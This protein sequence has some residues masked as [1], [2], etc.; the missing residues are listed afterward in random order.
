MKTLAKSLLLL[1][2][3]VFS[4]C[5]NEPIGQA[6]YPTNV[7]YTN[8]ELYNLIGRV[9]ND[10]SETQI[11]CIQFIYS[12]RL[13]VFDQDQELLYVELIND[14]AAFSTLLDNLQDGESI[15]LN[16]PIT[17]VNGNGE[18]IEINNNEELKTAIDACVDKEVI[19]NCNG[20][21]CTEACAWAVSNYIGNDTNF[22][23]LVLEI[24]SDNLLAIYYNSTIY[25]GTWIT[26]LTDDQLYVNIDLNADGELAEAF[27]SEWK[28]DYYTDEIMALSNSDK[29]FEL[30]INCELPCDEEV[31]TICEFEPGIAVFSLQDYMLCFTYTFNEDDVFN[32][33]AFSFYENEGDAENGENPIS[34][35]EYTNS[36]N[37][38]TIYIRATD[39]ETGEVIGY[40]LFEIKAVPCL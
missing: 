30:I 16:Y 38:Q 26:Y 37:P 21:L 7:I 34:A 15:G 9:T 22:D 6:E 17:G 35:S 27:N 19:D 4:A 2:V 12:F 39:T 31:Y 25:Y 24:S 10:D 29:S 32:P 14:N 3:F 13:F 23:D 11:S 1:F 20:V 18:L 33:V 5:E 28:I 8:S 40:S 36:T